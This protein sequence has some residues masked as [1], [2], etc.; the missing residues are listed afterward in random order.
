MD[1]YFVWK[2]NYRCRRIPMTI[3][4]CTPPIGTPNCHTSTNA[5]Q[6]ATDKMYSSEK[7]C[8]LAPRVVA[9]QALSATGESSICDELIRS[10]HPFQL[11]G[12]TLILHMLVWTRPPR[13][14]ISLSRSFSPL[15]LGTIRKKKRVEPT[16][17]PFRPPPVSLL[18]ELYIF[19]TSHCLQV[20]CIH[21]IHTN[22][23]SAKPCFGV[24]L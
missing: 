17:P 18:R 8:Y 1:I 10:C 4:S 3:R 9:L 16:P 2:W 13:E 12:T 7:L 14:F 19:R 24:D 20:V 6:N 5:A 22:E 11:G 15:F 23:S 21:N